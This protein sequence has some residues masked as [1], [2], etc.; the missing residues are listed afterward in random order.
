MTLLMVETRRADERFGALWSAWQRE[1]GRPGAFGRRGA[2]AL[3]DHFPFLLWEHFPAVTLGAARRVGLAARAHGMASA[4]RDACARG[5]DETSGGGSARAWLHELARRQLEPLIPPGDP[6]WRLLADGPEPAVLPAWSRLPHATAAAFAACG[7]DPEI[8]PPVQESQTHLYAGLVLYRD[9]V[10]WKRDFLSGH[11]SEVVDRVLDALGTPA[12]GPLPGVPGA[13]ALPATP[14]ADALPAAPGAGEREA[15][16]TAAARAFH[17]GG[18]AE[19]ALDAATEHLARSMAAV[20]DL[21]P[22]SWAAMLARLHGEVLRLRSDLAE[23]RARH[24]AAARGHTT[25]PPRPRTAARLADMS[26]KAVR[27]AVAHMSGEQYADGHWGDFLVLT[28][29]STSWATGYVGWNLARAGV[30]GP[31]LDAAAR[32]LVENRSPGGAWGYNGH[33]PFDIDSTANALLFLVDRPGVDR[34]LLEPALDHLL[35]SQAPD[36]GFTTV[37]DLDAW[38]V[39]FRAPTDDAPGWTAAHP[40]VTA[41]V[42]LLLSRVDGDRAKAAAEAALTFLQRGQRPAGYWDAYWW[43]GGLYTTC[44]AVQALCAAGR[45]LPG[46]GRTLARAAGWLLRSRR[47]DGGWSGG[48]RE[49]S[50]AFQTALAVQAL[51]ALRDDHHDRDHHDRD[52]LERAVAGGVRW[53]AEHQLPDGSWPAE[54][55]LRVPRPGVIEPWRGVTWTESILGLDI[56]VPDWR[57]LF[58]GAAAVHALRQAAGPESGP[59][60]RPTRKHALKGES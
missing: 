16:L 5:E 36:G 12:F 6:Y 46:T 35:A 26:E 18:I 27:A 53:L 60:S 15:R 30:G 9:C 31:V 40:C 19:S 43:V 21:P 25:G 8:L 48:H 38:L 54:P 13:G 39:R 55:I 45:E 59:A 47:A 57:R 51:C 7:G 4:L 49:G 42:A 50:G 17:Y 56:V 2:E 14:G 24:L 28:Q 29:Q 52:A 41:M 10:R 23:T 44:R 1:Q 34:A 32:W 58:T 33:W 22:V 3:F 37:D 20:T 11:R